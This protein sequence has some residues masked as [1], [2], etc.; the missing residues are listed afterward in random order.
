[1]NDEEY[2]RRTEQRIDSLL[3]VIEELQQDIDQK[4]A[5]IEL[6]EPYMSIQEAHYNELTESMQELVR[7]YRK[8]REG[9]KP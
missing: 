1:M 2:Q 4:D 6:M 8:A 9:D 5:F 7:T 3:E